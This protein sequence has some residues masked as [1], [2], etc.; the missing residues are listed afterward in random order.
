[1]LPISLSLFVLTVKLLFCGLVGRFTETLSDL[2]AMAA[3]STQV[4]DQK[5]EKRK[6]RDGRW[7]ACK[8]CRHAYVSVPDA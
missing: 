1:M 5:S 2:D 8:N 7:I 6:T 3:P 4:T